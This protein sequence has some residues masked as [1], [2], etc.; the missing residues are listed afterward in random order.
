MTSKR[1]RLRKVDEVWIR[2]FEHFDV[3]DRIKKD[4]KFVIT[5]EDIRNIGEYEA[6][7]SAKFDKKSDLP[8]IFQKHKLAL[9]P[10]KRGSYVVGYYDVFADLEFDNFDNPIKM[11][12][13]DF[14]ET[15]KYE[16][17]TS[18]S[19]ALNV[20][21]ASGM[22]DDFLD[23]DLTYL[24]LSG[25]MGS[26]HFDFRIKNKLTHSLDSIQVQNAQIE[27]D[28]GFEGIESF[29]LIEAKND[30][31][32]DFMVRQLYY[33]Y[34]LIKDRLMHKKIRPIFFTYSKGIFSFHEFEFMKPDVYSSIQRIGQK[35]YILDIHDEIEFD[36]IMELYQNTTAGPEPSKVPFPQ[37]DYFG[38]VMNLLDYLNV[39]G[40][41]SKDEITEKYSFNERQ[42]DYYWNS[43]VYLG[44]GNRQKSGGNRELNNY[45]WKVANRFSLKQQKLAFAE[46]MLQ[47]GAFREYFQKLLYNNGQ[48]I[49]DSDI[50]K[51]MLKHAPHIGDTTINRRALTLKS[52]VHWLYNLIR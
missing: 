16:E 18:E 22:I 12:L 9:L 30:V 46:A 36:E 8:L 40:G 25:R 17:I 2:L 19:I 14:L 42:S 44:F 48:Q 47:R 50:K 52:W 35:N 27:I 45:G 28:G 3:L 31:P 4:G 1:D 29:G 15:V 23:E 37:A 32:M 41:R 26:G 33:P 39:P 38:R 5:S 13:P 24:A 20:A 43:L 51:I 11:R 10:I 6:R 34:L 21:Y 7:L 49:S